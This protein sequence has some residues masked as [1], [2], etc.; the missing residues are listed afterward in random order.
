MKNNMCYIHTAERSQPARCPLFLPLPLFFL[1]PVTLRGRTKDGDGGKKPARHCPLTNNRY[2]NPGS[3]LPGKRNDHQRRQANS[4]TRSPNSRVPLPPPPTTARATRKTR[5]SPSPARR[6]D[7]DYESRPRRL[8][9]FQPRRAGGLLRLRRRR[10]SKIRGRRSAGRKGCLTRLAHG[11][12]SRR[13]KSWI[14]KS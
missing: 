13:R 3:R 7:D 12:D 6:G 4:S 9:E 5:L 10:C 11:S 1:L 14:N 8:R 2:D